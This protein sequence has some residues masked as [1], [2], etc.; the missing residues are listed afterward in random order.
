MSEEFM[1]VLREQPTERF[2]SDLR[3]R[4]RRIDAAGRGGSSHRGWLRAAA[5]AGIALA[6]GLLFTFPAVRATARQFL[7]L[8]RVTNFVAVPLRE[9]SLERL[10]GNFDL[11]RLIGEQ[12]EMW[13]A[14]PSQQSF[15]TV[16]D[17]ADDAGMQL[18]VP[19]HLPWDLAV[20][21]ARVDSGY[22]MR[23]VADTAKLRSVMDVFEI[24]DLAVPDSLDGEVAIV[25]V[26]TIVTLSYKSSLPFEMEL[27]QANPPEVSLPAGID[28]PMLAEIALRIMG[29]TPTEARDLANRIDWRSTLVVPIAPNVASFQQITVQGHAAVHVEGRGR[30]MRNAIL[31]SDGE[32]VYALRSSRALP[33]LIAIANSLGPA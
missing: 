11:P 2:A 4:L 16:Q 17:A 13:P 24:R 27:V 18:N 14:Q 19:Q 5:A 12:V 25:T 3:K 6:T 31:W 21:R 1:H 8:F 30:G 33:E 26:P 23:I 15:E 20:A 10:T 7:D 32:R 9:Q 28:L 22:V 29:L